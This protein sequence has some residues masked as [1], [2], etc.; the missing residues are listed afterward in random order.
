M[1]RKKYFTREMVQTILDTNTLEAKVSYMDREQIGSPDNVIIYER[2]APNP[3]LFADDQVHMTKVFLQVS[4]YKKSKLTSIEQLMLDNFNCE[5]TAFNVK[6]PDT[7][8][9]CTYYHF[10]FLSDG[11][12]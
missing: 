5:P 1:M 7:D 10:E 8:Y 3:S 9:W 12:W 6:Q 4:H 2:T 11:D